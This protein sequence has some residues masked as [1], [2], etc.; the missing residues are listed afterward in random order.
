M[1]ELRGAITA[2]TRE[3]LKFPPTIK[4]SKEAVDLLSRLLEQDSAKRIN[5][6]QL[7]RHQFIDGATSKRIIFSVP[8]GY[9]FDAAITED[10]KYATCKV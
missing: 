10:I 6:D 1:P 3:L 5:L 7:F 8:T 9:R 4:P 2:G